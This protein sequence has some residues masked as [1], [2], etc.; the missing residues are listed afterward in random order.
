VHPTDYHL[1]NVDHPAKL[2]RGDT[3]LWNDWSAT[4][5]L[6]AFEADGPDSDWVTVLTVAGTAVVPGSPGPRDQRL[7]QVL[8]RRRP[9]EEAP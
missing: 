3:V 8:P 4:S 9:K 2:N 5:V 6:A 7:L 1:I